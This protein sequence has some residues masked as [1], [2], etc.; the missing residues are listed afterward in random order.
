MNEFALGMK[1]YISEMNIKIKNISDGTGIE[2]TFLQKIIAGTRKPTDKEMVQKILDY[3]MLSEDQREDMIKRYYIDKNG[4]ENHVRNE[5]VKSL[6][7]TFYDY[8]ENKESPLKVT[9][10]MEI[11]GLSEVHVFEGKEEV[12]W[13]V[14]MILENQVINSNEKIKIIMQMENKSYKDLFYLL[15]RIGHNND[16]EHILCFEKNIKQGDSNEYNLNCLKGVVPFLI[17]R[18]NYNFFVYYDDIVSKFNGMNFFPY[19]IMAE[20]I[21][22]IISYDYKK[23]ILYKKPEFLKIYDDFY[24]DIRKK[25]RPLISDF[26]STE[27]YLAYFYHSEK[28]GKFIE[29]EIMEQPCLTFFITPQIAEKNIKIPM[30]MVRDMLNMLSD[31]IKRFNEYLNNGG[32]LKM[33]FTKGGIDKFC[34]EGIIE[35]IDP[36]IYSPLDIADRLYIMKSLLEFIE[37]KKYIAWFVDESKFKIDK[38]LVMLCTKGNDIFLGYNTQKENETFFLIEE[39]S[40]KTSMKL[41]LENLNHSEY[42]YDTECVIDYIRE[43]IKSMEK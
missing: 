20:D 31:R 7:E 30:D 16:F 35:E 41:F 2:R 39:P 25:T 3:M 11:E 6:F 18:K 42:V 36:N 17:N 15:G 37:T 24:N 21:V 26:K 38:R 4:K 9:N 29:F 34:T 32:N 40:I 8:S 14:K 12:F 33:Y 5:M 28:S 10:I 22:L 43:K 13:N 19:M 27:E 1:K 23:A